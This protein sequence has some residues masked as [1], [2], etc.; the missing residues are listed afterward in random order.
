MAQDGG[1]TAIQ[2][3]T[4]TR[5][6][7][8]HLADRRLKIQ[9]I[10]TDFAD[11]M[12]LIH[13]LE[14]I[15][16]KKIRKWNKKPRMH[17]Q[18]LENLNKALEFIKSEG[19]KLVG[20]GSNDIYG[21]N[22]KLILGLVWTLILRYQINKGIDEAGGEDSN[23]GVKKELLEWVN[24]QIQP[25]SLKANNF[26]Q[27]W[28]NPKI[29]SALTDSLQ[30]GI[31]DVDNVIGE[32]GDEAKR[33]DAI[34]NAMTKAYK[35]FAIPQVMDA[36]DMAILPDDLSVMTYVSYFREKADELA[37]KQNV[38]GGKS[39]AEG[40]GLETGIHNHADPREFTVYALDSD[41]NPVPPEDVEVTI[42]IK[43]PN[44]NDVKSDT[45]ILPDE[46]KCS[47]LVKYCPTVAGKYIIDEKTM[48]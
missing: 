17:I 1:R 4:F 22:L 27:D 36:S 44:G 18:K 32:D 15:S 37:R 6:I 24:N 35:N 26:K 38:A 33:T 29:L 40:P 19:L 42:S 5:W 8:T 16:G 13:L 46:A 48:I 39:Y 14:I 3:K 11:G 20:I 30:T 2:K 12:M 45:K 25:Y 10:T 31:I 28:K 47:H 21:G 41:G 34:E 7:N 43:D 23:T 9:D